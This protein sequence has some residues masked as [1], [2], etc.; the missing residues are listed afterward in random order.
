VMRSVSTPRGM[1]CPQPK[2]TAGTFRPL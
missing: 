1:Q 2:K